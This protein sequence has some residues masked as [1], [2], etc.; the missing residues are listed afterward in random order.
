MAKH[1]ELE[2]GFDEI[3][4]GKPDLYQ[5]AGS[6]TLNM[7]VARA[8]SLLG[9]AVIRLDATSSRLARVNIVLTVVVVLIGIVQV[10]LMFRSK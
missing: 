4:K 7:N 2:R 5:T 1:D 9:K 3:L 8:V 6:T 10:V